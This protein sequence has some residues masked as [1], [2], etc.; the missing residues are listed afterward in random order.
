[1][2]QLIGPIPCQE[3]R[4]LQTLNNSIKFYRQQNTENFQSARRKEERIYADIKKDYVNQVQI[5]AFYMHF[6][7]DF[8]LEI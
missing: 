7:I 1:M 4:A 8:S 3:W 2:G 5:N 6:P